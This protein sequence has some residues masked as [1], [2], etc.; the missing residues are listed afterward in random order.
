[1][2]LSKKS[3]FSS[4]IMVCLYP[5]AG[6]ADWSK[7]EPPHLTLVYSGTVDDDAPPPQEALLIV[8]RTIADTYGV[9]TIPV[10]CM[11][12]LGEKGEANVVH[13]ECSPDLAA[14]RAALVGYSRSQ[15]VVFKPHVTIDNDGD[16]GGMD[17]APE[18]IT[19]DRI[20]VHYGEDVTVYPLQGA[21]A[22]TAKV[23]SARLGRTLLRALYG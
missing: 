18:T 15:Y 5:V 21:I 13:M 7:E 22:K 9:Q 6:S 1:M 17:D 16:E 23:Y 8:A 20:A 11:G 14:M 4:G 10:D 12:K 2:E 19:F 3:Q